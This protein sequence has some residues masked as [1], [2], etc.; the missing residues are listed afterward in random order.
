VA[1]K[2]S[3]GGG[4]WRGARERTAGGSSSRLIESAPMT[5]LPP[6][7]ARGVANLLLDMGDQRGRAFTNLVLQK[8]LYFAHARCLVATGKPLM[9]GYFEA[10]RYG[11]VHPAVYQSFRDAR[12]EIIR[13]RAHRTDLLSGQQSIVSPPDSPLAHEHVE[14]VVDTYARLPV[15]RLVEISHAPEAPWHYVVARAN[16]QI[17]LGLRIPDK[18]IIERFKRHKV[19]VGGASDLG[20]SIEDTPFTGH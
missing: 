9:T 3:Q 20:E 2:P 14:F 6:F 5:R 13:F 4:G 8:L 18:V 7:D 10:W 19:A 12:D 17:T 11:P 1:D 16:K 15:S